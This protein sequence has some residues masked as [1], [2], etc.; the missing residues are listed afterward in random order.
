LLV[1]SVEAFEVEVQLW[2]RRVAM[3]SKA[4]KVSGL[5]W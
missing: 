5:R 1:V 2:V 4:S 3:V